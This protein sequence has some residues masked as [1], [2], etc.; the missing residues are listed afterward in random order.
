MSPEMHG[1]ATSWSV[2]TVVVLAAFAF[3][4]M[5][6]WYRLSKACRSEASVWRASA[7]LSGELFVSAVVLS[8]LAHLDH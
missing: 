8:P 1:S 5:R 4:Y 6:G 3:I 2:F 7:F